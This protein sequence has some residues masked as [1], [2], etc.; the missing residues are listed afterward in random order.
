MPNNT[1]P[2]INQQL[3]K[4]NI[5]PTGNA[6][7]VHSELIFNEIKFLIACCQTDPSEE[8]TEFILSYLS[9]PSLSLSTITSMASRHGI[10]PL[11]YKTIKNLSQSDSLN[12]QRSTLNTF[13]SELK[14]Y[15]MSIVQRNMLMTSELIKIMDLLR[16]NS[17]EALAFK[18]P[19]LA[20]MVYEDITLR[21]Y[22]D[23]DVLTRKENIYK[24]DS[25][26][27]A[28][29]YK[30]LL[31]LTPIQEKVWIKYAHDM[32]FIHK[33]KGVHFEM[34]WSFL[35]EDYPMQVNL[36]NFWKETQT[37]KLNG[38]DISTFSNENLLYYLCIHGSKHLWERVEW[39]KD[40]DLLIRK[41]KV[42]W[43][44]IIQKAKENNFEKMVYLGLSLSVFLFHTPLPKS[45]HNEIVQ[46]PQVEPLSE[47]VLQSWKTP[48][49]TFAKT[50]AMLK[51]FP[52]T[53]EQIKYL[54]KVILKPSFNEYWHIDLPKEFS[55]A[56]YLVRPYLL[57][58]KY[59]IT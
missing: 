1:K 25:L 43:E 14:P 17:I 57:I 39:I 55:W 28:Y 26:L 59:F 10:L 58:K 45:I 27:K 33:Q 7:G 40:I 48:K 50:A 2:S 51:L 22:S 8:D 34:H 42:N 5:A 53:K 30:R 47:F 36:E 49:S 19:A 52:G 29:G 37:V 31:T 56:Y 32:G 9:T 6:L 41:H 35:D 12:A 3:K 21:Q 18:G 54:H 23:L 38:H 46:Y 4:L 24:I 16:K 13:L 20:Q 11:V 15:Y 44:I